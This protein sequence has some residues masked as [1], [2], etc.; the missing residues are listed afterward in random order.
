[1]RKETQTALQLLRRHG[2]DLEAVLG[3]EELNRALAVFRCE[4][5]VSLMPMPVR[6]G[7]PNCP[8]IIRYVA[9]DQWQPRIRAHS[10]ERHEEVRDQKATVPPSQLRA[11]ADDPLYPDWSTGPFHGHDVG[12]PVDPTRPAQWQLSW[13][14]HCPAPKCGGE[15]R[16]TNS[17]LLALLV[18][19]LDRRQTEMV[20]PHGRERSLM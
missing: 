20:M 1:M 16:V 9:L 15:Y 14:W 17:R 18:L 5:Y 11:N 3:D 13:D 12:E 8:R 4:P 2:G 19:A 6:C 10:G 7:Q